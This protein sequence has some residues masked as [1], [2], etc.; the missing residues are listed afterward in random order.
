MQHTYPVGTLRTRVTYHEPHMLAHT[1]FTMTI[2]PLCG[3]FW[4]STTE[5]S[6]QKLS[7]LVFLKPNLK[8]FCNCGCVSAVRES[9]GKSLTCSDL[10]KVAGKAVEKKDHTGAEP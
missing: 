8:H 4:S 9:S 3:Q 10:L 1:A 5:D 2:I 6:L 7:F